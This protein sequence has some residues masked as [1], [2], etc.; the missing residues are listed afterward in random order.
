MAFWT[1][2]VAHHRSKVNSGTSFFPKKLLRPS[3]PLTNISVCIFLC[4]QNCNRMVIALWNGEANWQNRSRNRAVEILTSFLYYHTSVF[5][6]TSYPSY[7]L[8][9]LSQLLDHPKLQSLGRFEV[10]TKNLRGLLSSRSPRQKIF[11]FL[12]LAFLLNWETAV[13]KFTLFI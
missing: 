3:L 13:W 7:I 5:L 8:I 12:I 9:L 2:E 6:P 11:C 10:L 4:C 1:E